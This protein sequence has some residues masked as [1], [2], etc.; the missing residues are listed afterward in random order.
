MMQPIE[1]IIYSNKSIDGIKVHPF[2]GKWIINDSL[3]IHVTAKPNW[4][5]QSMA[6]LLLGWEWEDRK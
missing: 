1:P 2:V 4:L 5:H 3:H 6:R